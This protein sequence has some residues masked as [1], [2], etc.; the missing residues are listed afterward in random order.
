MTMD[1]Y[2]RAVADPEVRAWAR[3]H[4]RFPW[5][6]APQTSSQVPV[7]SPVHGGTNATAAS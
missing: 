5:D 7:P 6:D 1:C 4:F 2:G 3:V